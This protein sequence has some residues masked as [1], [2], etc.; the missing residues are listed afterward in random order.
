MAIAF[1]AATNCA[2]ATG[3]SLTYSHTTGSGSDRHLTVVLGTNAA[4][5][6]GNITGITYGGVAMTKIGY[7]KHASFTNHIWVYY[8][9][10]PATGANNVVV[11]S[12][13]SIYLESGCMSYTGV[14]QTTPVGASGTAED[15]N[16]TTT[17]TLN[18]TFGAS[19]SWFVG[20]TWTE[21][22]ITGTA[23]NVRRIGDGFNVNALDSNSALAAGAQTMVWTTGGSRQTE[24]FFEMKEPGAAGPANLKSLDTNVKANIKSYNTNVLAN[25][26]SINTNA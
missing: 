26:K 23:P 3:T 22:T 16:G 18:L 17:T 10:A 21:A 12:T 8:L 20:G 14:S 5:T 15:A 7:K 24:V 19:N 2:S 11:S 1:D 4:T 25:I 13:A 6:E 9:I